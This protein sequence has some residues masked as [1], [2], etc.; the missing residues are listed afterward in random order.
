MSSVILVRVDVFEAV[1][2][3]H[4]RSLLAELA[5]GPRSAGE[6]VASQPD[7]TQPAVSRHLRLLR[8]AGLVEARPRAQR[9]FYTLRPQTLAE[10]D[11]WLDGYRHLWADRLDALGRYLD[12]GDPTA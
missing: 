5:A 4:R 3:R 1:A 10:L 9:R 2:E 7:L 11:R 8:E 6:L 12:E